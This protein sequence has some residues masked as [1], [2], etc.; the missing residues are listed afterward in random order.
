MI[1]G[2]KRKNDNSPKQGH[3]EDFNF[4]DDRMQLLDAVRRMVDLEFERRGIKTEGNPHPG[5]PPPENA[6][7]ERPDTPPP[8]RTFWQRI[9]RFFIV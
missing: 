7:R 8:R 3:E 2:I 4:L 1:N 5:N 6:E 9:V